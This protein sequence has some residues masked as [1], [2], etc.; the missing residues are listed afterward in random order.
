MQIL[1]KSTDLSISNNIKNIPNYG[2]SLCRAKYDCFYCS[3]HYKNIHNECCNISTKYRIYYKKQKKYK[4]I[5]D[6]LIIINNVVKSY[7]ITKKEI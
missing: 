7:D 4:S 5:I 1:I 6:N 2:F 3:K